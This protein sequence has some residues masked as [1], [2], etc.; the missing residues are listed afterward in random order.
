MTGQPGARSS[1]RRRAVCLGNRRRGGTTAAAAAAA[2]GRGAAAA[3]AA[4]TLLLVFPGHAGRRAVA[5]RGQ[6]FRGACVCAA[7]VPPHP[8]QSRRHASPE[9]PP[10]QHV[11]A[12]ARVL[13]TH[14][15]TR[16]HTYRPLQAPPAV[17]SGRREEAH[18]CGRCRWLRRC[19]R[20][21][22]LRRRVRRARVDR[23]PGRGRRTCCYVLGPRLWWF[24]R[25]VLD[26]VLA[27]GSRGCPRSMHAAGQHGACQRPPNAVRR[28]TGPPPAHT[29]RRTPLQVPVRSAQ[30]ARRGLPATRPRGSAASR[31]PRWA[32]APQVRS[33]AL[34]GEAPTPRGRG[35]GAER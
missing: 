23:A 21:S 28:P 3:L 16:A 5:P 1:G 22:A 12:H 7:E 32:V 33:A 8:R 11:Q 2:T 26:L 20:G 31:L 14:T 10:H 17:A 25:S 13:R 29:H 27:L 4:A 15:H 9:C 30:P 34:R 35:V 6:A 24:K 19:S 18:C